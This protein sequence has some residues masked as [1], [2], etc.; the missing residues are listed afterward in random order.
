[1][2]VIS[3]STEALITDIFC[4]EWEKLPRSML[5]HLAKS[6]DF[7]IVPDR[8]ISDNEKVRKVIDW[9]RVDRMKMIRIIIRCLDNNT[10]VISEINLKKYNYKIKELIHLL[11]RRPRY[12][13]HFSIDLDKITTSDAATLLSLGDSYILS[14]VNIL[15]YKFN[16]KESM[17]IIRGYKFDRDI[18]KSVNYRSLKGYQISEIL[19]KTGRKNLDLF[20]IEILTNIDWIN[21]LELR[22]EMLDICNIKKFTTG[23]IF[24]SIKLCCMFDSPD[25]SYLVFD[26]NMDDITPFG[27]EKLIIEKPEKFLAH[28]NFS[29]LED[30][31]WRNIV[32][33]HPK[34]YLCSIED[35]SHIYVD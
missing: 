16:F 4:W 6:V 5:K 24:Y 13:E 25:L 7:N 26:R 34:K 19:I 1:M 27:W 29:K 22:P 15:K 14:K 23:D 17:N 28:C 30:K 32:K 20:S 33:E 10:D 8:V 2:N 21:L 3:I 9:D 18:I 35:K 11:K 12:I 31:N